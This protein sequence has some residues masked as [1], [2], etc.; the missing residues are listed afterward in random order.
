MNNLG[1]DIFLDVKFLSF[2]RSELLHKNRIIIEQAKQLPIKAESM[3]IENERV[4]YGGFIQI[5]LSAKR[6][7]APARIF[8]NERVKIPDKK[9][10]S[11]LLTFYNNSQ[12]A[13]QHIPYIG[14]PL[15]KLVPDAKQQVRLHYEV[16]ITEKKCLSY[17][18]HLN[19]SDNTNLLVFRGELLL[20]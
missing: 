1:W 13:I 11:R 18:I 17:F 10:L 6:S 4:P 12:V 19:H 16:S 7:T 2:D 9:W 8:L 20:E 5:L 3:F 15:E 14:K